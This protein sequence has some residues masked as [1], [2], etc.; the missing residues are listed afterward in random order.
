M[1]AASLCEPDQV[2]KAIGLGQVV[3]RP[4]RAPIGFIER[5]LRQKRILA[6][7]RQPEI[8][9][10]IDLMTVDAQRQ[11]SAKAQIAHQRP[12]DFVIDINVWIESQL[13]ARTCSPEPDVEVVPILT[14]F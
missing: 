6:L 1:V 9:R 10:L 13:T 14:F 3:A 8:Y 12:P 11:G 7:Y 4:G 2:E 5:A